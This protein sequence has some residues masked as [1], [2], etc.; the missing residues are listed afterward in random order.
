MKK[1]KRVCQNETI[2]FFRHGFF[3]LLKG[4]P[5]ITRINYN[6]SGIKMKYKS[7]LIRAIRA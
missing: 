2:C 4:T 5:R 6:R 3:A 1:T 7:V